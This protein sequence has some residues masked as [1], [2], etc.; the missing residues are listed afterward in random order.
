MSSD[1]DSDD[2]LSDPKVAKSSQKYLTCKDCDYITSKKS[3]FDKH[4]SSSKHCS[5]TILNARSKKLPKVANTS[6]NSAKRSIL[7]GTAV[8]IMK[9]SA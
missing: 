9:N 1:T 2:K 7:L 4:L 6:A 8:G 3:N 5:R